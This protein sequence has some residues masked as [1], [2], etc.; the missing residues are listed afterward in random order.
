MQHE[1]RAHPLATAVGGQSGDRPGVEVLDAQP[2]P[3]RERLRHEP[4]AEPD[5]ALFVDD[6]RAFDRDLGVVRE[7][8]LWRGEAGAA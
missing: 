3:A 4:L 2:V 5:V 6:Q 7:L 8:I 1:R